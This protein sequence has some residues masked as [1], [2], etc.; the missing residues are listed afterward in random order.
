MKFLDIKTDFAFKKVFGSLDSHDRLI[1]F[2]NAIIYTEDDVQIK[3]LEIIDP[4]NIPMLKGMKD[5]FVDV[6]AKLTDNTQVIIEMQVLPHEGFEKR[7]LYNAAKNYSVQLIKGEQY[8]LLNPIIALNIVD[9]DMFPETEKVI[10]KFKLLEKEE[11][12]DYSDDLELIFVELPKFK[13]SL[14]SLNGIKDEWIWFIKNAESLEVVPQNFSGNVK[15]ALETVN[16]AAMSCEELEIQ[17]KK[18]EF[19][20]VQKGS[21]NLAKKQG[22]K[23]GLE[24]GIEQGIERG[25]EKVVSLSFQQGLSHDVIAN[26]TGLDVEAIKIMLEKM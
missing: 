14:E 23:E 24:Q 5:S 4:Y 2:L 12:I 8:H 16:E 26:I 9:F 15:S 10:T 6:K 3:D 17:H 20:A 19:I 1:S 11:F 25:I 18:R 13:K 21:L 22:L 7:I